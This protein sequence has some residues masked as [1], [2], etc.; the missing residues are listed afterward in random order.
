MDRSQIIA[1]LEAALDEN[2]ETHKVALEKACKQPRELAESLFNYDLSKPVRV[3]L[4]TQPEFQTPELLYVF[5]DSGCGAFDPRRVSVALVAKARETRSVALAVDWLEKVLATEQAV[6]FRITALWGITVNSRVSL[7]QEVELVPVGELPA[8][9][10]KEM[11][12]DYQLEKSAQPNLPFDPPKTALVCRMTIDPFISRYPREASENPHR[13][14]LKLLNEILLVLTLVGPCTPIRYISWFQFED[15][16]LDVARLGRAV[17]YAIPEIMPK[18]L[19]EYGSF[20]PDM[21][22][23]II[24]LYLDLERKV[25]KKVQVALERLHQSMRRASVGDQALEVSIAL[26][27]LL[28]D[29]GTENTYKV[30][31]RSALLLGGE[32][33][34]RLD[35]R[36]VVSGTYALRSALVHEG[37]AGDTIRLKRRGKEKSKEVVN[38]AILICARVIR[39]IL[40]LGGI[41]DWYEFELSNCD[42]L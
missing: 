16:D 8:S 1:A 27:S 20:D 30:G 41:P 25:K 24:R 39:R 6:G 42:S 10:E 34:E 3:V 37:E 13:L 36:T 23:Q 21:A 38:E 29:G 9:K 40:E 7:T 12:L 31:L 19:K 11:L 32:L 17:S 5:S 2:S 28:A 35:I 26:E 18:F 22:K 4:E 33:A 14:R 15:V